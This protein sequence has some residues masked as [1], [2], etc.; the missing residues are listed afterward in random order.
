VDVTWVDGQHTLKAEVSAGRDFNQ[1]ILNALVE[2]DWLST[3]ELLH[4]Y[5]QGIYLGQRGSGWDEDVITRLGIVWAVTQ[6]F[7]V[8]GQYEQDLKT[9]GSR[10]TDALF[11]I[12][13][14]VR[15]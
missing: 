9:Y 5:L 10:P 15:F 4:A 8:S 2:I 3:D 7:S 1:D 14:R 11:T 13:A 6:Y 12:Q